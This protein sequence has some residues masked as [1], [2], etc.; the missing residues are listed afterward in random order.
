MR[1]RVEERLGSAYRKSPREQSDDSSEASAALTK[2][3]RIVR[4]YT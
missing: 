4:G 3:A 2:G 1:L